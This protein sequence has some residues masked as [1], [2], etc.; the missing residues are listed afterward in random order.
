MLNS[1]EVD[2]LEFLNR[3]GKDNSTMAEICAE[4]PNRSAFVIKTSVKALVESGDVWNQG[5]PSKYTAISLP[6]VNG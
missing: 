1:V 4:F 5:S 2:I 3:Q 6:S